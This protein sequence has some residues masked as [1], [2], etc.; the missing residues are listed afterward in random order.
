ML[1]F[2]LGAWQFRG[3][4]YP[5]ARM[6]HE[7]EN[8]MDALWIEYSRIFRDFDDVT[9][10]RWMSQTL[11]Q[12]E[13]RGWRMS[14][15]LVASYRL[16]AQ[17]GHDRQIWL[18]RLVAIPAAYAEAACCRA[19]LLPL[20]SRDV[21]ESGL[22]CPHCSGTAVPF[23]E[24]PQELQPLIRS[25]AEEYGPVHEVAHWDEKRQ[26]RCRDYDG[27]FEEAATKIETLLAFAAH[28]L[29]P[30]LAEVYP[31]VLWEDHDECLEVRPEDVKL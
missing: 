23:E 24:I 5:A 2:E 22:L 26:K 3:P 31:A 28:Q 30:K 21:L 25:W 29:V 15:P 8:P 27:A 7:P 13:G 20:L 14:H 4:Q 17:V 1:L 6:A 9:L 18:K 11:G 19:P 16:A 12:L 10:A